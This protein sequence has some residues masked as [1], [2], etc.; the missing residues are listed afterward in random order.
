MENYFCGGFNWGRIHAAVADILP[1]E[2]AVDSEK[3]YRLKV[4]LVPLHGHS[5]HFF[6][7]YKCLPCQERC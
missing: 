4:L 7:M 1:F 5:E 2:K 3:I 6:L